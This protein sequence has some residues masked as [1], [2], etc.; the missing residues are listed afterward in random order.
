M[1]ERLADL[2]DGNVVDS[3]GERRCVA[4]A[5]SADEDTAR[6]AADY[7]VKLTPS[8]HMPRWASRLS[9]RVVSVSV[10]RVEGEWWWVGEVE[11]AK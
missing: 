10:E 3:D 1:R 11:V 8:I 9:V 5:A 7:G 2:S 4:W 6:C